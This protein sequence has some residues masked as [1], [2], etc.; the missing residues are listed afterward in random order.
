MSAES[1]PTLDRDARAWCSVQVDGR[2]LVSPDARKQGALAVIREA[3][4]RLAA[5]K[6]P[7]APVRY[8]RAARTTR[9]NMELD[10]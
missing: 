6:R 5:L 8:R 2:P 9:D 3:F 4:K 1:L 10:R 7:R